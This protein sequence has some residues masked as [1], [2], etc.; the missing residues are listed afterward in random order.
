MF[1]KFFVFLKAINRVRYK[2]FGSVRL[3]SY[4]HKGTVVFRDEDRL[5]VMYYK[6][7]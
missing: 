6:E 1:G 4:L 2:Y 3:I 7:S 5:N